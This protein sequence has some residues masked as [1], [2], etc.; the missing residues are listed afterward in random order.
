[1]E[2]SEL[3]KEKGRN[4]T[5]NYKKIDN[6]NSIQSMKIFFKENSGKFQKLRNLCNPCDF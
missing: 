4:E 5:D 3:T 2:G 1:M 6:K